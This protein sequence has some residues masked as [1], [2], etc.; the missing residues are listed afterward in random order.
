MIIYE[1]GLTI[2]GD[3]YP[4]YQ[5]WLKSHVKKMLQFPGFVKAHILKPEAELNIDQ[6][7][8]TVQYYLNDR[9]SLNVYF[10]QFAAKM[11]AEATSLFKDKF[12]AERKVYAIQEN[13]L[14]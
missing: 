12:S 5:T 14:K 8:L 13:I 11:R 10:D 6:E 2:D 1:V 9:E 4:Q 3:I 7:K